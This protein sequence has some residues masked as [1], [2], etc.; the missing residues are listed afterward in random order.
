VLI[1][2]VTKLTIRPDDYISGVL[3]SAAFKFV[4][5]RN[6]AQPAFFLLLAALFGYGTGY[7]ALRRS[8][9]KR[10]HLYAGL[11]CA[12]V[13]GLYWSWFDSSLLA[14]ARYKLRTAL[15]V[16]TP[17][18]AMLAVMHASP[19]LERRSTSLFALAREEARRVFTPQLLSG[20]IVLTLLVQAVETLKF[21]HAWT[22]YKAAVRALAAGTDFDPALGDPR[23]VSSKRIG[24]SLNRLAW[25]STTPYLSV[26]VSPD[27]RPARLVIDPDS[28]YFWLSCDTAAR[29]EATSTAIPFESRRMIR[30][31]A[32]LHRP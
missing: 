26:L 14:E 27:L 29:S 3:F 24:P 19:D 13:L 7:A 4:D 22:D 17:A 8:H 1:W 10:P 6:L 32:C 12:L 11:S 21:V 18:F 16:I 31:Y 25:N 5:I 23:F 30:R 20:A 9:T 15:L 28:N 2:L